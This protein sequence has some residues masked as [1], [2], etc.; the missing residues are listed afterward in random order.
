MK[1][2]NAEYLKQVQTAVESI[3]SHFSSGKDKIE[4]GNDIINRDVARLIRGTLCSAIANVLLSGFKSY[5]LF[6]S[7]H[8]WD[9]IETSAYNL[10][11]LSIDARVSKFNNIV[12]LL[13]SDAR[14]TDNNIKYRSF[15]CLTLNN[16]LLH[17]VFDIFS[18]NEDTVKFYEPWSF[19][20]DP[21]LYP[22]MV[23]VLQILTQ[24]PF[25]LLYDYEFRPKN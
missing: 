9:F 10:L 22:Q 6:G 19:M 24:F 18:N 12:Q 23:A 1:G 8:M 16:K 15:I 7:Y 2:Q 14:F 21:Q 13:N 17:E 11:E 20:R 5:R 25:K 3:K 4:L